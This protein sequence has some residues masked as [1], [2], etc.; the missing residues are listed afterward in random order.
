[1]WEGRY[2]NSIIKLYT[3]TVTEA[4]SDWLLVRM[5]R[6]GFVPRCTRV[7]VLGV[8]ENIG[9]LGCTEAGYRCRYPPDGRNPSEQPGIKI[10]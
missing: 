5:K 1:M 7:G 3:F 4:T 8:E 6:E 2:V 10:R 9:F